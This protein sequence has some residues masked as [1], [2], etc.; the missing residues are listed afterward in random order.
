MFCFRLSSSP[1]ERVRVKVG[2][3]EPPSSLLPLAQSL[4]S[5]SC[6]HWVNSEIQ[7]SMLAG[8][9]P[10]WRIKVKSIDPGDLPWLNPA[11]VEPCFLG[12]SSCPFVPTFLPLLPPSPPTPTLACPP[13]ACCLPGWACSCPGSSHD[14]HPACCKAMSW[15]HLSHPTC[16]CPH[17][18]SHS[19]GHGLQSLTPRAAAPPHQVCSLNLPPGGAEGPDRYK[20][21]SCGPGKA[22]AGPTQSSP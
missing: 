22:A 10:S 1:E 13:A 16:I 15:A 5:S 11:L 14:W 6:L 9:A 19:L 3:A 18:S 21:P 7:C 20:N 17:S 12:M 2:P 4:Q 8:S